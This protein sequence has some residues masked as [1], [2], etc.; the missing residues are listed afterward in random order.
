MRAVLPLVHTVVAKTPVAL[1][2]K[3]TLPVARVGER[4]TRIAECAFL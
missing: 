4:L 1:I 2:A 3:V